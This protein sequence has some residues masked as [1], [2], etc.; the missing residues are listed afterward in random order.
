MRRLIPALLALL[1]AACA[2]QPAHLAAPKPVWAFQQSDLPPDPAFRFGRLDNGM[3]FIIRRNATPP[4]TAQV[5][6][7]IDAGSLNER[8][9]ERGFAHFVEHM[10]FNGSAHVPEGEMVRLLERDGLAFG[11]DTNAQTSFEQTL[12]QLD[13][14]RTDPALLDTALM[15]MR[16]TAGELAFTPEAVARERG[17]VL[18]ELRDGQGYAL[19]AWKDQVAFLYPRA[20]YPRRLPIGTVESLNAATS[21]TLRAFW[22]REYVPAKATLVVV[23]D[24][25]PAAAEQAI[26]AHFD[27]WQ[28]HPETPRP[29]EGKVQRS[30]RGKT[31]IWIAPALSERVTASR[32]GPWLDE[33]DTIASRRLNLLRQIGYGIVNRRFLRMTRQATPP[34][35]GA[36]FGT[37]DVFHIGRTTNLVVDT[38]DKGWRTGLTAATRALHQALAQ[39]FTAEEVA[40][41]V[42]NIRTALENAAA[43]A[44]TRSNGALVQAALALV[45]DDQVPTTPQSG[46]A[47]FTAFAP[48]ITPAAVLAALKTE[49]VPLD[50]P[51]LRFQGRTAPTGGAHA[52]R[53]A[54]NA[55]AGTSAQDAFAP[56]KGPFA[57]TDFGPAGAIVADTREPVLGIREVR[58]ANGVRLNLRHTDL[59]RDRIAIRLS[60]D[61]GELLATRANPLAVEMASLLPQGGLGKHSQDDL[62]TLLA[63]RSISNPFAPAGEAFTSAVTTTPRDLDLQLQLL[64]A[65]LSDPGY[66]PEAEVQFRA[67]MTNFFARLNATPQSA[68]AN[69]Q[70]GLLSDADPRFTLAAPQ[71]YQRL[72]FAKL[73]ADIGDRLAHGALEIG[74]V[75]DLD[76]DAAIAA[77]ARTFGALPAREADFRAYTA[78]RQRPFTQ[79]RGATVLRHTGAANQAI[80]RMVWPTTDDRDPVTVMG[81]D[82]LQQVAAIE[83]LDS[84]RENLGKAYS[85]GASSAPSR[86]WT[87]YGTFA[88]QASVD[89]ADVPATRAALSQTIADLVARPVDPDILQRARAPMREKLDAF[90]KTNGG[91]LALADRAQ[92]HADRL[93][94]YQQAR[95]RLDALTAQDVQA[96]AR[97]YLGPPPVE[98]LVLP[99]GAAAP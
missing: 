12:Y 13:L 83:V 58:F 69:A 1:L 59:D 42:A 24:F 15:L 82:L 51:L 79:K 33:R 88:L 57:Y 87:G 65:T 60:V 93:T 21:E 38:E 29:E 73:K 92:T 10:A 45:R 3:R 91:W 72:S 37:S 56:A 23:G 22:S 20:T 2:A 39:G 71:D 84:V 17:V 81:L 75:G 76:E 96:L 28:P 54:W 70:G 78:E 94:R 74:M 4:G 41:Q 43:G 99:E 85:P 8:E 89:V 9:G 16:E 32:H 97:R 52:L 7:D 27:S 26:R 95:A 61:G 14:P 18:S 67:N 5:R 98:I 66:R 30:Y 11:A 34:F 63:G 50:A 80:V 62:Q 90:L 35:R 31:D 36:G 64:A 47:R 86:T 44:D 77:V 49:A 55:A 48:S 46:L 68:L 40:E 19:D 6:L 25:D 53:A